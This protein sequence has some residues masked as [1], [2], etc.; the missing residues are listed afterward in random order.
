MSVDPVSI[1]VKFAVA[2][3][4]MAFTAAQKF[5]GPRQKNLEVSTGAYGTPYPEVDGYCRIDGCI[6]AWAEKLKEKKVTSKT[7]G[8]K[9]AEWRYFLTARVIAAGH[10][11]DAVVKIRMNNHLVYQTTQAGPISPLVGFFSGTDGAPVKLQNGK[12]LRIYLGTEDQPVDPRYAAWCEDRYGPNSAPAC[13][14][15]AYILL[16]DIP[17]E[18]LGNAPP[19]IGMDVVNNP[20]P[21]Y[22]YANFTPGAAVGPTLNYDRTRALF[23]NTAG[24]QYTIWDVPTSTKL[25]DSTLPTTVEEA[26][27]NE[28][29]K[30]WILTGTLGD[31]LR[32]LSPDGTNVEQE[33]AVGTNGDRLTGLGN[34]AY[35]RINSGFGPGIVKCTAFECTFI[36]WPVVPEMFAKDLNDDHWAIGMDGTDIRLYNISQNDDHTIPSPGGVTGFH[37]VLF[38]ADNDPFVIVNTTAM[39]IDLST[40][41]VVDS[42]ATGG[43]ASR[44]FAMMR[45][46]IPGANRFYD[47][48]HEI[49][50]ATLET[51]SSYTLTD[52]T[53]SDLNIIYYEPITHALWGGGGG[54]VTIRYLDRVADQATTLGTIV[55]A[56]C[57]RRGIPS[58]AIDVTECTQPVIG[59]WTIQGS[60]ADQIAP[61]LEIHDVDARRHDF[62]IHFKVKGS[63]ADE[64]IDEGD[65]VSES[66]QR[67]DVRLVA[68]D[69]IPARVEFN[70]ADQT[71]DQQPNTASDT[72]ALDAVASQHKKV[73]DLSTYAD[74]PDSAQ[75]KVERYLRRQWF[76]QEIGEAR[77]SIKWMKL[78]PGDVKAVEINGNQ[79]VVRFTEVNRSGLAL[80]VKWVRDDPRV[81]DESAS[82][83]PT[84]DGYEEE[85]IYVSA[86]TK[87]QLFDVPF[88]NDLESDDRPLLHY[89]ASHYGA[90][91]WP[92]AVFWQ[93]DFGVGEYNQWN[94]VD[95][96]D[97]ATWGYAEDIL[98]DVSSPWVWD[99][100][101]VL[102]V[103]I[104]S[105]SLTSVTEAEINRDPSINQYLCGIEGRWEIGN[106]TTATHLGSGRYEVSGL[107]RGRRGTEWAIPLH[108][109]GDEFWLAEDLKRDSYGLSSIGL[110]EHFKGQSIGRD[111]VGAAE[112]EIDLDGNSLRP[113]APANLAAERDLITGNWTITGVRR[114]RLGG[115]WVGG[116]LI[117]LSEA[118]EAYEVVI[119]D[120]DGNEIRD[121]TV[122]FS[123]DGNFSATY[124]ASDQASD[125]GSVQELVRIAAYQLSAAVGR[126]FPAMLN[127]T[128]TGDI[129]S[130]TI[131]AGAVAFQ[132]NAD[133]TP[134]NPSHTTGDTL[135]AIILTRSGTL[136]TSCATAGWTAADGITNPVAMNGDQMFMFQNEC[137]SNEELDPVIEV[138]GGDGNASIMAVVLRIP[139]RNTGAN[140][141]L[142]TVSA[143][144]SNS[145]NI[146]F[147][148]NSPSIDDGNAIIAIGIKN[149]EYNVTSSLAVISGVTAGLDWTKLVDY[150]SI[151]GFDMAVGIDF[152]VNDTGSAYTAGTSGVKTATWTVGAISAAVYLEVPLL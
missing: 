119:L 128:T 146:A 30:L 115:D 38:N 22:L 18:K 134:V 88:L 75:P 28:N 98:G 39:L 126:G 108:A 92:G 131:T 43:N 137:D 53:G 16:E 82:A 106:F 94:T 95:S 52:W 57:Q 71:A 26:W 3:A 135:L 91:S 72:V 21:A 34:I 118:S 23:Y 7:K 99:R 41:T 103:Q 58:D 80:D 79:R 93:G 127:A 140:F 83:G 109:V 56:K 5:E 8:G 110:I 65:F 142:G 46:M 148:Q 55:S 150:T 112:L 78:E 67:F 132:L 64:V 66:G 69:R 105:G 81:H 17:L 143:N 51:V 90:G 117:P 151:I 73:F 19:Q 152:A 96:A 122:T 104:K 37:S 6:Y 84:L 89:G 123:G 107:R 111:P 45:R 129:L 40:D 59:Y 24:H 10:E 60:G 74:E 133:I 114:T 32:M 12:N 149:N 36:D 63:A 97:R 101:N 48:T 141:V 29:G 47:E 138:A 139:G 42:V 68:D 70:Y 50:T 15:T 87:A 61:L 85:A 14:G 136:T 116:S 86:P 77:L 113:Y 121:L 130:G 144:A 100:G 44:H 33:I 102:T 54:G 25:I 9:Y 31:T 2:G 35:M 62:G 13:R 124:T 76:E 125:F 49:D 27:F 4:S 145:V 20:D 1:G 147:A 120:N 11:I